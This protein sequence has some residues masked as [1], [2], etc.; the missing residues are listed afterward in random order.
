[1]IIPLRFSH[2]NLHL[3]I[4]NLLTQILIYI[5]IYIY[6]PR[7]E[8]R[9]T[10]QF[11]NLKDITINLITLRRQDHRE[12]KEDRTEKRQERRKLEDDYRS[13]SFLFSIHNGSSEIFHFDRCIYSNQVSRLFFRRCDQL[14]SGDEKKNIHKL[15]SYYHQS[16]CNPS[17]QTRNI[18]SVGNRSY[19][20]K[21]PM[22]SFIKLFV[23]II[24]Y[25][26]RWKVDVT[27]IS[28]RSS[29][30]KMNAI[31]DTDSISFFVFMNNLDYFCFF[32]GIHYEVS[33]SRD[34]KSH[35]V[36]IPIVTVI[37]RT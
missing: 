8:E 24:R 4:E 27:L 3:V 14:D 5:Y 7:Y 23:Y 21:N 13:S 28:I 19:E 12:V 20:M 10:Y 18:R 36:A 29:T 6:L 32:S 33:L 11:E 31:L 1:M 26:L 34:L 16:V 15:S 22:N 35:I 37:F 30:T 2:S 9:D 25:R 17:S